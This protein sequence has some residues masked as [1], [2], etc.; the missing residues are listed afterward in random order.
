MTITDEGRQSEI[1][2]HMMGLE[3]GRYVLIDAAHDGVVDVARRTGVALHPMTFECEH[4]TGCVK[5]TRTA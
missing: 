5:V 3:I 2:H 4:S 1:T